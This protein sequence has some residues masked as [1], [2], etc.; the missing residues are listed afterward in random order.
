MPVFTHSDFKKYIEVVAKRGQALQKIAK[1]RA[2]IAKT[3]A[4]LADLHKDLVSDLTDYNEAINRQVDQ[5][6]KY[7]REKLSDFE[8]AD[9][10]KLLRKKADIE[11]EIQKYDA[12]K[13]QLKNLAQTTDRYAKNIEKEADL[14]LIYC[15]NRIK[16]LELDEE[17]IN[18]I[19]KLESEKVREKIKT[20]KEELE[21][22]NSRKKA[23]INRQEEVVQ[24]DRM[25]S[26]SEWRSLKN[27]IGDMS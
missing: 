19:E 15:R 12:L 2:E 17:L 10:E 4:K 5:M 18:K 21:S 8:Q 9:I 14:L 6:R 20:K 25:D 7:Y 24:S 11:K 16:I 26:I 22:E 27:V 3:E 13:E 23:E 1:R